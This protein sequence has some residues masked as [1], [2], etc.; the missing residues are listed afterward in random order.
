MM[1]GR[2]VKPLVTISALAIAGTCV[3]CAPHVGSKADTTAQPQQESGAIVKT[4]DTSWE[5][6]QSQYPDEVGSFFEGM[7]EVE[8]WDGK[9]H[10]HAMLFANV[11]AM[12]NGVDKFGSA[13]IACKT[14][15][16][17]KLLD[18]QGLAAF[19]LPW[20]QVSE[21]VDWY[22]C[23]LCHED[24][25]PGATLTYGGMA[26]TQFGGTLLDSIDSKQ[27][28]CG[29]CHNYYGAIYTR[30]GLMKKFQ[31]GEI[32]VNSVDPYRYGTDPDSLMKA[33]L[34]D[35]YEMVTDEET[36]LQTFQ[37]N[38]PEVEIF[39]GSVHESLGMACVDCHSAKKVDENGNEYQSHDFSSSP[40]E[41]EESLEYCLTCHKS[42]G[43]ETTDQMKDF[44]HN[45]QQEVA[46]L[47]AT[48]YDKQAAL[49]TLI[50]NASKNG[51][52]DD[53]TL[54]K[55]KDNYTRGTWYVRYSDGGGDF[56]GQKV[57]HNPEAEKS[58]IERASVLMD[59]AIAMLS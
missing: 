34:E 49:K 16:A 9:V 55:A 15:S 57:A 29:Q 5:Q 59:D 39:Q 19:S 13:C 23:A 22:D 47:E 11:P 44:V 4:G 45:A 31:S 48:F 43:V 10:S 20:S 54:A 52:V 6:W 46:D 18:E 36:G 2:W 24:G 3:A 37:A 35:G 12:K 25:T 50:V 40:L 30:G 7:T 41:H 51:T 28:V 33:A 21:S 32:D 14:S 17:T 38:H 1:K 42:Q 27:A 26:A 53:A 58:Y 8:G 56:K